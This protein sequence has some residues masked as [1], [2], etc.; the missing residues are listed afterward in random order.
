MIEVINLGINNIGSVVSAI[1]SRTSKPVRTIYSAEESVGPQLMILPGTGSFGIAAN[2]M[3]ET[4]LADLLQEKLENPR[5][6]LAGI[7]LGM[8]LLGMKSEESPSI[9][10]L[11]LLSGSVRRL[12]ETEGPDGRVPHVGW[13]SLARAKPEDFNAL[14]EDQLGDVYFSHSYHLV[15]SDESIERFQV[16]YGSRSFLAAMRFNNVSG[17][18]FHPEKSSST[19]LHFL[20]ELLKWSKIEN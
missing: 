6:Y 16:D 9:E 15:T 8:Q 5:F 13:A 12:T 18:Q 17:Y 4:G 11:G 10:G 1:Q 3:R 7:C 14:S 20:D 19:G 2:R